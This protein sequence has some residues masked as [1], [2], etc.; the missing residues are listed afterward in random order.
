MLREE[1]IDIRKQ[2]AKA[3]RFVIENRTKRRVGSVS[4]GGGSSGPLLGLA[5]LG[6][7]RAIASLRPR[8]WPRRQRCATQCRRRDADRKW[9]E[10]RA[11]WRAPS[12]PTST[13]VWQWRTWPS[14][15]TA[16]SPSTTQP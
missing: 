5:E 7:R 16:P 12:P 13:T 4:S 3:G 9:R 15:A 6:P 1:Q 8:A 2:R 14:P 11:R 10:G